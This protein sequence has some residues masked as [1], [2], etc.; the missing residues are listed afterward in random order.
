MKGERLAAMAA[1]RCPVCSGAMVIKLVAGDPGDSRQESRWLNRD[2]GHLFYVFRLEGWRS[3]G[4]AASA[5]PFSDGIFA[6]LGSA[7]SGLASE[8]PVCDVARSAWPRLRRMNRCI[9]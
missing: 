3:S 9:A 4:S 8:R 2:E 1:P 7:P 5:R 6:S